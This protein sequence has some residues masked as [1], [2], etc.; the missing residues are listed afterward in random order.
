MKDSNHNKITICVEGGKETGL[1]HVRRCIVIARELQKRKR[2]VH[3]F[4]NDDPSVVDWIR[5][6]GFDYTF[7]SL[8][9]FSASDTIIKN[10]H[11]FMIDTKKRIDE[12]IR[13]LKTKGCKIILL[14]NVTPSRLLADVVIYPTAI[15][16]NNLDWTGFKAKV[17]GGSEYIPVA[18]SFIKAGKKTDQKK[19][20]PPYKILVTMG[21]SDPN[22]LTGKIISSLLKSQVPLSIKAVIGPAFSSDSLL[23]AI[24]GG[25]HQNLQVIRGKNELSSDMAESHIAITALGTTIFELACMGIPAILIANYRTDEMDM[26]AFKKLGIALPLGYHK[27]VSDFEIRHAVEEL[28][29]DKLLW[30]NISQKAK[31][32]I[33]GLGTQRI[34]DIIEKILRGGSFVS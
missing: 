1:G 5:Q 28:L 11:L 34:A 3:F 20:Q 8:T 31:R 14:D 18:E 30:E 2:Y 10:D 12:L 23:D 16:E 29:R 19:L 9:H 4:I 32:L 33:D 6:N 24:L 21:G 7:I 27:N 25:R 17:F 22:H 15:Y 13:S 26:A